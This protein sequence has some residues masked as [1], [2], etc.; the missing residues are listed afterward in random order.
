MIAE[1]DHLGLSRSASTAI[2]VRERE[3]GV[4]EGEDEEEEEEEKKKRK[5]RKK[6]RRI[7]RKGE[8][9]ETLT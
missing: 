9:E 7:G 1:A 8:E 4:D 2:I 6:E 3:K 5:E